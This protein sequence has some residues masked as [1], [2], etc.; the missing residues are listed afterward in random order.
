[1]AEIK[2]SCE[3][4][5]QHIQCNKSYHGKQINCPN[6]QH[7]ILVPT[8]NGKNPPKKKSHREIV[9]EISAANRFQNSET[10]EDKE[11]LASNKIVEAKVFRI[12]MRERIF[13]ILFLFTAVTV[14]V[15]VSI[16]GIGYF[17]NHTIPFVESSFGSASHFFSNLKTGNTIAT[18]ASKNENK[19]LLQTDSAKPKQQEPPPRQTI[20]ATPKLDDIRQCFA[21]IQVR[22]DKVMNEPINFDGD[23]ESMKKEEAR[24]GTFANSAKAEIGDIVAEL[25][26]TEA[27][28]EITDQAKNL[29]DRFFSFYKHKVAADKAAVFYIYH[30][31]KTEVGKMNAASIDDY[32]KMLQIKLSFT[33]RQ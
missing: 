13:V 4:C 23:D 9:A 6:C 20:A 3:H 29:I 33:L 19:P 15:S 18:N 21:K 5:G 16:F 31:K 2:F 30:D 25:D 17:R 7:G 28:K 10:D 12:R 8:V 32:N 11:I 14:L 27:S 1:M 22:F 26:R 24:L